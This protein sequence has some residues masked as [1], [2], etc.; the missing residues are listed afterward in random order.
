MH[1]IL[2]IQIANA[3]LKFIDSGP[4]TDQEVIMFNPST[5]SRLL[6]TLYTKNFENTV[7]NEKKL[8]NSIFSFSNSVLY[9]KQIPI[10]QP[11]LFC[12]LEML[13][14]RTGQKFCDFVKS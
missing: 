7:G 11:H 13:P 1:N 3:D 9:P 10:F 8:V 5:Q 2:I 4:I 14:I 6:T 12:C